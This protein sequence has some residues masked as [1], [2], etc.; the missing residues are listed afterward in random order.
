MTAQI[1]TTSGTPTIQIAKD[2]AGVAGT[3]YDIDTAIVDDV[4]TVY[5]LVSGTDINYKKTGET[6]IYIR[7]DCVKVAA[8]TLSIKTMKLDVELVCID[9]EFPVIDVGGNANT[10][11]CDQ[12]ANSGMNCIVDLMYQDRMWS[13]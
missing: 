7:I 1:N 11:Q 6:I 10:I 9:V 12:N 8:A 4:E 2:S 13:G 3:Y 5:Q